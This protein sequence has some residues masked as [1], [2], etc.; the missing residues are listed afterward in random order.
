[1][2]LQS[3]LVLEGLQRRV[4]AE[5]WRGYLQDG[6]DGPNDLVAGVERAKGC[7]GLYFSVH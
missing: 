3:R 5:V 6:E 7:G 4:R 2:L 1:M